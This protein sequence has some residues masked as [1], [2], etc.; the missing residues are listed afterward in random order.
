MVSISFSGSVRVLGM[1]RKEDRVLMPVWV[2]LISSVG[3]R[4]AGG[5]GGNG[6]DDV[7]DSGGVDGEVVIGICIADFLKSWILSL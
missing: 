3:N 1:S 4:G 6:D 5:G 2:A 7:G